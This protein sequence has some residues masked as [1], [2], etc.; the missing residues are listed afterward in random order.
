VPRLEIRITRYPLEILAE[1][2][3]EEW[4]RQKFNGSGDYQR[5]DVLD[6]CLYAKR[7]ERTHTS[8]ITGETRVFLPGGILVLRRGNTVLFADYYGEQNLL[9]HLE[10]FARML[11]NL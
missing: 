6:E 3:A 2:R 8:E 9:D 10:H 4:S 11:E 1:M 5:L 7:E